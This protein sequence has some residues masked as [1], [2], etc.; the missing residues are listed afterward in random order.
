MTE[1][2][3]AAAAAR[4][5]VVAVA[6]NGHKTKADHPALPVT[7]E[8]LAQTAVE[9]LAAGAC[10]IHLHVRDRDGAHVL[11]PEAYRAATSRI[12]SAVG[13]R[14][15]V[16]ITSEAM[17]RYQ[18]ADQEAA[19]LATNPEAVSLSL[20]EFAPDE[21]R[22]RD[23]A[24]FLIRLKEKRVWPQ[25]ILYTPEEA[26]RLAGMHK[27][28]VIPF[29]APSAL[30]VLG[31]FMLVRAAAPADLLPFL[32]PDMPRFAPWGA[33]AFG[34]REAACVTAAALLGGQARVGFENNCL[35]P[36]GEQAGSNAELVAVVAKGLSTLGYALES[37]D[38]LR[39]EIAMARG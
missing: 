25:F 11:D 33:C 1:G 13:D 35:L 32:A 15:I 29:E 24:H 38:G 22:E 21:A 18:R 7:A 27:R 39:D 14:L 9:C 20:R 36:S 28:G 17:G 6:P 5:V 4:R 19:I 30:Y 37:A 12:C 8:E 2:S 23:F 34:R 10:M 3:K 16:Q 31:R 26:Q